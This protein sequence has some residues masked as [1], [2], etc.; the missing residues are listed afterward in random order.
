VQ[1]DLLH[2]DAREAARHNM[3]AVPDLKAAATVIGAPQG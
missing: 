1:P 3:K 2:E